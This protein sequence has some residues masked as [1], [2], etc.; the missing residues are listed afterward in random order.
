[1]VLE[2]SDKDIIKDQCSPHGGPL[3]RGGGGQQAHPL[4]KESSGFAVIWTRRHAE[5]AALDLQRQNR[6]IPRSREGKNRVLSCGILTCSLSFLVTS[7]K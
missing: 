2:E 6:V 3:G 7:R 5:K 4:Q 1:M